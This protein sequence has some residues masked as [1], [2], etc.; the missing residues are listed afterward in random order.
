MKHIND[1]LPLPRKKDPTIPESFER[2]ALKA[3]A[4]RP[5]DRFQSA[6]EMAEALSAAAKEAGIEV[7]ETISIPQ[8]NATTTHKPEPV[9]VFSGPARQQIPDSGFASGD[10]AITF[11]KKSQT[12]VSRITETI[13]TIFTPPTDPGEVNH[14]HVTMA[15]LSSVGGIVAVNMLL[16]WLSGIFGWKVFGHGWPMEIL[17]VGVLLSALMAA[18]ANPWLLIPAGI[19]MGNGFLFT[20]YALTGWWNQ[21]TVLWPLE[22][23]L[24]GIAI[25]SPFFLQRMGQ[26]GNWLARRIGISL[27]ILAAFVLILSLL[28]G[29]ALP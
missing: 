21:W 14:Q 10:T 6:R 2:V 29:I 4:K 23:L 28:A 20:Y 8:A 24:A 5:E 22:P 1:P 17:A 12:G 7:P 16:L 18:L 26:R 19:V 11:G 13:K 3:L 15:V 25:V 27:I 9:A